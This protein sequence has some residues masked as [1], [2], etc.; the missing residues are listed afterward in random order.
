MLE[1]NTHDIGRDWRL[2]ALMPSNRL[3]LNPG[4]MRIMDGPFLVPG[5][6][7]RRSSFHHHPNNA[8]VAAIIVI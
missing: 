2:D 7:T 6:T 4:Q 5:L 1:K 8:P 3:L